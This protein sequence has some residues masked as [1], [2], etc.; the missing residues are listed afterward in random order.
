MKRPTAQVSMK[1]IPN[2]YEEPGS[3]KK[4]AYPE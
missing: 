1:S 4:S 2:P 3:T